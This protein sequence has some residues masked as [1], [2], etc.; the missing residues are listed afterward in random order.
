MSTKPPEESGDAAGCGAEGAT[1]AVKIRRGPAK[2]EL[3]GLGGSIV[4]FCLLEVVKHCCS[5]GSDRS[6]GSKHDRR[7]SKAICEG[8]KSRDKGDCD[9]NGAGS[10]RPLWPTSRE[11]VSGWND[12]RVDRQIARPNSAEAKQPRSSD[13]GVV[14]AGLSAK[15][16]Y[17]GERRH[18]AGRKPGAGSG[19]FKP[20][21]LPLCPA[22]RAEQAP[23][24][25][26]PSV[27]A[28]IKLARIL[29]DNLEDGL[30]VSFPALSMGGL[31]LDIRTI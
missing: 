13:R 24:P 17:N 28:I 15:S 9:R 18:C 8:A 26:A 10:A 21:S 2:P 11:A 16:V 23:H 29:P 1:G 4:W 31:S 19:M 3:R 12:A 30:D 25:P 7:S 5:G 20:K 22:R 14:A 6:A 27:H